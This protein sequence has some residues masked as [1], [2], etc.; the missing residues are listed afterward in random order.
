MDIEDIDD[1][2]S[3]IARLFPKGAMPIGEDALDEYPSLTTRRFPKGAMPIAPG[4]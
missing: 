1:Y 2:P 3:L 4:M